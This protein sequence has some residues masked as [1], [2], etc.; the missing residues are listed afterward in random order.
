M[1]TS[2]PRAVTDP[3]AGRLSPRFHCLWTSRNCGS[4]EQDGTCEFWAWLRLCSLAPPLISFSKN[5]RQGRIKGV[6]ST[7]RDIPKDAKFDVRLNGNG[8]EDSR[9]LD[10]IDFP[11]INE[12]AFREMLGNRVTENTPLGE[13]NVKILGMIKVWNVWA[14]EQRQQRHPY[15]KEKRKEE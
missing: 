3:Y 13:C 15:I 11:K 10:S 12:Y 1:F 14:Q 6:D 2:K 8:Y 9:D 5:I 4:I 7:S